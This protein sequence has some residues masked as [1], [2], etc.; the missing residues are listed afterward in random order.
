MY[1]NVPTCLMPQCSLSA[2]VVRNIMS[3][4]RTAIS[5]GDGCGLIDLRHGRYDVTAC[6]NPSRCV[7]LVV[8]RYHR[9]FAEVWSIRPGEYS[10]LPVEAFD[11]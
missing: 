5:S 1:K 7:K 8:R 4:V 9:D 2:T 10:E 3:K 11:L 6:F